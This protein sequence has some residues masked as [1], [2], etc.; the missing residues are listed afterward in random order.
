[1]SHRAKKRGGGTTVGRSEHPSS[2]ATAAATLGGKRA[3]G[4]LGGQRRERGEGSSAT[5]RNKVVIVHQ[6]RFFFFARLAQLLSGTGACTHGPHHR[7]VVVVRGVPPDTPAAGPSPRP[8]ATVPTERKTDA[9]VGAARGG[10]R[11]ARGGR[12]GTDGRG[13]ARGLA[14]PL[15]ARCS[16]PVSASRPLR[17][18]QPAR[19]GAQSTGWVGGQGRLATRPWPSRRY[20]RGGAEACGLSSYG[21]H[22]S[23][24]LRSLESFDMFC[25]IMASMPRCS[26]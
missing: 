11:G 18:D 12:R 15:G 4:T 24:L 7:R 6:D 23:S 13:S 1:M 5:G 16:C 14:V 3:H 8:P 26:S 21:I 17:G 25:A 9:A 2:M 19:V 22:Y 20:H 10:E